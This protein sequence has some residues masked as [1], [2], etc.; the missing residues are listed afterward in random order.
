MLIVVQNDGSRIHPGK[1]A[2]IRF[3]LKSGDDE[4]EMLAESGVGLVNVNRRIQLKYGVTYGLH[5]DSNDQC[6]VTC[7]LRLPS[8]IAT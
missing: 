6:G 5:I 4:R 3:R 7:T 2:D 8:E 1:V